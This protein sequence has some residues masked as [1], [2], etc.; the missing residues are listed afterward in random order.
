MT[1][2]ACR[3]LFRRGYDGWLYACHGFS[4]TTQLTAKDGSAITLES[5][6]T[7]RFRPD[8]NRVEQFTWGQVNPFGSCFTADGDLITS[9]CHTKPLTML[10]RGA[11]YPSFGKPDDGLGFAPSMMDHLHESTGL[12]GAAILADDRFPDSLRNRLLVGNVVTSRINQ[13]RLEFNG[14][15]AVAAEMQDFL[16]CDDPWFRPVD[17]QLGP[18]GAVCC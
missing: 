11:Y 7:Y 8:A 3:T 15:T 5:G 16:M 10:I 12:A 18:D 13:D 1:L 2:T 6:N 4:N 14:A 9:D 17:I